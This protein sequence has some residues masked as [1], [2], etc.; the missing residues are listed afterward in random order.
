[1]LEIAIDQ[2]GC[3]FLISGQEPLIDGAGLGFEHLLI[4][5]QNVQEGELGYVPA[6]YQ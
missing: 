4:S 2:F 3:L 5:Q 1:M 6:D